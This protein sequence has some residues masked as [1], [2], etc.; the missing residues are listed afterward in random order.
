MADLP[1]IGGSH[2]LSLWDCP[3]LHAIQ[4]INCRESQSAFNTE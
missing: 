4:T 1:K 2:I 3:N